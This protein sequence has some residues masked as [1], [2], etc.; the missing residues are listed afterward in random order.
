M[1]PLETCKEWSRTPY[2]LVF[3]RVTNLFNIFATFILGKYYR[4]NKF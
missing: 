1:H 3:E 4:V 2:M